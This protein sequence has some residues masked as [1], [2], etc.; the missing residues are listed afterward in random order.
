MAAL[1]VALPFAQA[2]S[3]PLAAFP[4][5][6]RLLFEPGGAHL[7]EVVRLHAIQIAASL[8]TSGW[9]LVGFGFVQLAPLGTLLGA[10]SRTERPTVAEL[11]ADGVRHLPA[12]A[13]LSG[14]TVLAQA[15][16]LVGAGIPAVLLRSALQFRLGPVGA[17]LTSASAVLAVLLAVGLTGV[18]QDLARAALVAT[19]Q[20]FVGALTTALRT[21][22]LGAVQIGSSWLWRWG[23]GVGLVVG[24]AALSS[25]L[26]PDKAGAGRLLATVLCQQMAIAGVVY[27][28]ASWLRAALTYVSSPSP[29][30]PACTA[31]RSDEPGDPTPDP[32][33]SPA[34]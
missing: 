11:L 31:E 20:G 24:A 7:I 8:R 18:V 9:L 4:A 5:G 29:R 28:R 21:F 33:A 1:F 19:R 12:F 30:S 32:D 13:L 27:L 34:A 10:L 2:I 15:V 23:V 17:D 6:E 25:A 22:A 3:A 16:L 14:L 26:G